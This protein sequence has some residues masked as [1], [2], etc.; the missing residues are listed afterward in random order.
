MSGRIILSVLEKGWRFPGVGPLP[1]PWSLD[2]ALELSWCL[3][4]CH[5]TNW[6][7]IKV[8]SCLPSW[9]HLIWFMLCPR[10]VTFFQKL[11]LAPFPPVTVLSSCWWWSVAKSCWLLPARL[12]FLSMGFP[13]QAYWS[14]LPFPPP[15]NIPDPGIKPESPALA[16]EF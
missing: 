10:A 9:S 7:R 15:S 5:F 14:G 6:L 3:W 11:C 12:F 1:T 13:R 2:S 16:G 8:Y 4:V